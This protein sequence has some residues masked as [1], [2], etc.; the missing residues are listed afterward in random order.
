MTRQLDT[1]LAHGKARIVAAPVTPTASAATAAPL[2]RNAPRHQ[3]EIDRNFGLPTQFYGATVALYLAFVGVMFA[4]FNT[5]ELVI[6][7]VIFA[8]FIVAGFGVPALWVRLKNNDSA[9]M[10]QARFKADG[11]MTHTGRLAP[12]DA[13]IQMLI[14]PSLI[15]VW[16]IAIAV[17]A[18]SV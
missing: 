5:P 14:L 7:M 1:V 18:A 16:G 6:P 2:L 13:A 17:I 9:T 12:R 11:I 3:V 15:V 8:L 10:S 4:T